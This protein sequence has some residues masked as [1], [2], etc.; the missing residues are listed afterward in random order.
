MGVVGSA[1]QSD[2]WYHFTGFVVSTKC[3]GGPNGCCHHVQGYKN[4]QG[5]VSL[6]KNA[7]IRLIKK[8]AHLL[9]DHF[10][11]RHLVD[12]THIDINI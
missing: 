10:T 1:F 2:H 3:E 9:P 4:V 11:N 8:E 5:G 7:I 6:P 12:E